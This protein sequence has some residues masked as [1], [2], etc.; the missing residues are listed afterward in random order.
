[1]I[2]SLLSL[3]FIGALL[4]F[5]VC[6]AAQSTDS[7]G[8]ANSFAAP[9]GGCAP[10]SAA[11]E[12]SSH[13]FDL[14]NLDRSVA[15][16]DDFFHFAAGGW[17]KKNPIPP[18]YS[19]W[20]TFNILNDRNQDVLKTILEQAS[21]DKSAKPG[22]NWQKIGDFYASCM[23]TAAIDAAGI[24]PLEPEFDRIAAIKNA[25]ELQMEFARLEHEGVDAGFG[26]GSS[27]DY[28]DSTKSIATLVQGGLGLPDR[29][30][31]LRDE[32]KDKQLREAY[33]QHVTNMFKLLGDNEEVFALP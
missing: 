2:R 12:S 19:R 7:P 27:P 1:M 28:K 25:S 22:S 30:Y 3:F 26:F 14:A 17:I 29:E 31:Y 6:T 21:A 23:D 24:K 32:D 10:I 15:P 8:S 13:G 18:A 4:I 16:C 20:G 9:S 33:L 11:D 5:A